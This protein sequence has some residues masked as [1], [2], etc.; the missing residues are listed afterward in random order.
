MASVSAGF[1][2]I[3][4]EY[5]PDLLVRYGPTLAVQIGFDSEFQPGTSS[6]SLPNETYPALVDTGATESCIDSALA[7]DLDLPVVDRQTVSGVHGPN[8]V[9]FHLAQIYIPD[10]H[11]TVYGLFAGVHLTAGG[12]PHRALMGRTFLS[13]VILTYEGITG[14]VTIS[15]G[16]DAVS[17]K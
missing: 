9:N 15:H 11:H 17:Q 4:D 13:K 16:N 6:P 14:S 2:N 8:A 3:N 12:Q 1:R 10:L 5:S 7:V